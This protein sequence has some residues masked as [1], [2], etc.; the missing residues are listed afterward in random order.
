MKTIQL[1]STKDKS[2]YLSSI[3]DTQMTQLFTIKTVKDKTEQDKQLY[4][5]GL[6]WGINL[7][8]IISI[9]EVSKIR[10][11]D[12]SEFIESF[13]GRDTE[14]VGKVGMNREVYYRNYSTS[15]EQQKEIAWLVNTCPDKSMSVKSAVKMMNQ[16]W[17]ILWSVHNNS[18]LKIVMDKL[19]KNKTSCNV[20]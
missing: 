7:K 5:L 12:L 4:T 1:S 17:C 11:Y 13:L 20:N 19:L 14:G 18:D 8:G 6:K 9:G 10:G 16:K 2:Y 15:K 3:Q